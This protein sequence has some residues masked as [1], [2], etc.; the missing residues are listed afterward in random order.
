MQEQETQ[1]VHSFPRGTGEEIQ[2]AIRKY[3]GKYYIDLRL[4]YQAKNE[5]DFRPTRK[6]LVVPL[7]RLSDIK[8]GLERLSKAANR[9]DSNQEPE[10]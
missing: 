1:V 9:L 4:W 2:I 6:G 10:V 5:N 7:E 3:K 8:E